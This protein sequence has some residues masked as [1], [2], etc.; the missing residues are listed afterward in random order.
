MERRVGWLGIIGPLMVMFAVSVM[1]CFDVANATKSGN[2]NARLKSIAIAGKK[3]PLGKPGADLAK[4][5]VV[6]LQLSLAEASAGISIDIVTDSKKASVM[7]GKMSP[8]DSAPLLKS[9]GKLNVSDGDVV[10]VKVTA[11]SGA[12]L[13]YTVKVLVPAPSV[14]VSGNYTLQLNSEIPQQKV[15]IEAYTERAATNLLGETE[16]NMDAK[17]W[18]L[19]VPIGRAVWFKVVVT[20][21]TGFTFGKVVSAS[22]RTFNADTSGVNLVL[23][24]FTAP[25][26]TEFT[27]LNATAQNRVK[28]NKEGTIDQESGLISF[29]ATSFSTISTTTIIDFHSLVANFTISQGSKLYVGNTEQTSGTSANNYYQS[30]T[31]TVVA[32]DNAQKTYTVAAPTATSIVGTT[33][34]QTQGFGV[35]NITTTD[36]YLGMPISSSAWHPTKLNMVWNPTG[37]FTYISPEGKLVQGGTSIKGHGNFSVRRHTV[38]SYSL[39]LNDKTGFDYYDYKTQKFVTLPAHKRWVLLAHDG[40]T[41]RIKTTLGFEMGRQVLD[42]MGWQPHADWVFFFLNG[43]YKGVYILAEVIKIDEGRLNILPEASLTNP[44][45][46]FI[47]EYNNTNWYANDIHG[48]E[49]QDQFIFDD[50]YN[51]MT[52]HLNMIKND[53]GN[54]GGSGRF[55]QQGIVW[56]FSS[57]DENL[58]WYYPDPPLGAGDLTYQDTT[59][60]PRKGIALHAKLVDGTDYNRRSKPVSEWIVPDDFGATNGMGTPRLLTGGVYGTRTLSQ[61]YPDWQTSAFVKMAQFIQN[62]EDAIYTRDYGANGAGGYHN[63]ID[64][65]SFID[66]QIAQEMS[67]NWEVMALNGHYMYYDPAIG[68]LKMG[69]IWDL[70]NAWNN[71]WFSPG[72]IRKTPLWYKELLGWERVVNISNPDDPGS[73]GNEAPDR[74]DPYYASRLKARWNEVKGKFREELDP[75]IDEQNKRFARITTYDDS[76]AGSRIGFKRTINDRISSLD[77]V[78]NGY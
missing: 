38:K 30:V 33:S 59:H 35:M 51:F 29:E 75:Y 49:W 31:F 48:G 10:V 55:K 32:E 69:L 62:A 26:M 17:R 27:L 41:T 3:V 56:S 64:I 25:E 78:I 28:Q 2:D 39:K 21:T 71:D 63:Y 42:K 61:V 34:W 18:S 9:S 66:W 53:S 5:E 54:D 47:V 1:A 58:G 74:K 65:D 60:F 76:V 45:G 67:S 50:M 12:V 22:G 72:N 70:D 57:P 4:A 6:E 20:D 23:D 24:G 7:Y 8:G 52:S 44:N 13:Y 40:E 16:A 19:K 46:G 73:G 37:S 11:G 14:T 68:K 15:S 43:A 77:P 36:L